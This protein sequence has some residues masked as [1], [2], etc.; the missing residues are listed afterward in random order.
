MDLEIIIEDKYHYDT[1]YKIIQLNL[2]TK[3]NRLQKQKYG[4]QRRNRG[5]KDKLGVWN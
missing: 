4:Y 2:F 3:Q 5:R 1:T